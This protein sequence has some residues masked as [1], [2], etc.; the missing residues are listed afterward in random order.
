MSKIKVL[1]ILYEIMPSGAEMMLFSAYPYWSKECEMYILATGPSEGTYANELRQRGYH[2][3][4]LPIQEGSAPGGE[5]K[6]NKIEHLFAFRKYIQQNSFDAVHIHKESL[7][8]NY[9]KICAKCGV[10]AIVRTVHS[11]F[12][13]E[14]ALRA[15]KAR[16]RNKMKNKYG[17]N[18][19]AISDGVAENEKNVFGNLCNHTIYNWC[20]DSKYTFICEEDK[21]RGKADGGVQDK[22]TI[23]TLATCNDVK[24]H[25]LLIR[26]I[27]KMKR[28]DKIYYYHVGYR[29]NETEEEEDLARELGITEQVLFVGFTNPRPYLERTD[30][31]VMTSIR[32]GLSIAALEAL[33][34]GVHLLLADSPGLI[35]FDNKGFPAVNYFHMDGEIP[36]GE[37]NV[38]R[39]ADELDAMVEMWEQNQLINSEQQRTIAS[40]IYSAEVGAKKYLELYL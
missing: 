10:K 22:F 14:G 13:F 39:L 15:R 37:E 36:A 31:F 34:S 40:R 24:N 19:V 28:K 35:E 21:Q 4:Y 27:A 5:S 26:A 18:F 1:H 9:A 23:L 3:D 12:L 6:I 20:D 17:V 7:S 29:K 33:F 32:E 16:S 25:E 8:E 30:L 11:T 2:I 38:V